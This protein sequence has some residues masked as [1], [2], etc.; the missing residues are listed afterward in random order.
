M[1]QALYRSFRP[2]N[3]NTLLG[4]E[5]IVR[6]LQNQIASGST[7]HAYLF[8]G[9]RGTGKTTTA[10]LLAKALNCTGNGAKPCGQCSA[11]KAIA[12]GNFLDVVEIDAASNN[13]VDDIRD[14]RESVNFPPAVGRTKV[15]IIDEA[16]M[17]TGP[18]ANALLK[19][20]EEP[21]QNVVFILATTE[22]SKLP[23]TILSRCLRMDFRRIPEEQLVKRFSEICV[24]LD[25]EAAPDALALIAVNADGSARDGLSLL[26]RCISGAKKLTRDDVLFLLGMAGTDT[27]LE[28]TDDILR[29]DCGAALTSFAKVLAEGKEAAQFARDWVEHLRDLIIIKYA[30]QPENI[31]NL[32]IEN[33]RRLKDQCDRI[34]TAS[35]RLWITE[36]SKALADAKWS[37]R[38]RI[39]IEL[40]IVRMV[41]GQ[42]LEAPAPAPEK[43]REAPAKPAPQRKIMP[44]EDS[45]P[46]RASVP[47]PKH[48]EPVPKRPEPD[49]KPK[50]RE[51]S[52]FGEAE[53]MSAAEMA[54]LREAMAEPSIEA[55]TPDEENDA[56]WNAV[57]HDASISIQLQM[58][59]AMLQ[60]MDDSSFTIRVSNVILADR[61]NANA[62]SFENLME[63]RS[64]VKRKMKVIV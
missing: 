56:L 61:F 9:T 10:R 19:T 42:A 55:L 46:K 22:P 38:P 34:D 28:I 25:V 43:R 8:C 62:S 31:L 18:A 23:A 4:Q 57:L 29:G 58:S 11:C 63:I 32:S 16:H 20:L 24:K 35:L 1:Y 14:L 17:L 6:I 49:E 54:E 60:E 2:E 26:D 48:E 50:A 12:A 51:V 47:A 5:H 13:G 30:K 3:F 41:E 39:L 27:F 36:L 40:A 52:S 64:G 45:A 44:L 59:G 21:P 7:G 33:I 37:P 53:Q 15:Y